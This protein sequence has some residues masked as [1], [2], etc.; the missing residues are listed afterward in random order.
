M[1]RNLLETKVLSKVLLCSS[2]VT[3]DKSCLLGVSEVCREAE[4]I[5]LECLLKVDLK[6]WI[7][8]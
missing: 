2:P 1:I 7:P 3:A 8:T 5:Y 4:E 6:N